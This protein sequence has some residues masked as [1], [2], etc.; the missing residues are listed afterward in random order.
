VTGPKSPASDLPDGLPFEAM[1]L[2]SPLPA[3]LTRLSDGWVLAVNDAWL[4]LTG[5]SREQAIGRSSVELGIWDDSN[6]RT[7]FFSKLPDTDAP[8][9]LR[10][11]GQL[12]RVRLHISVLQADTDPLLMGV[13]TGISRD[14]E[15]EQALEK[16]N[17]ELLRRLE[18]MEASERLAHLGHWTT[19]VDDET[20][21]WSKGLYEIAGLDQELPLNRQQGRSGIHP[22]DLPAWQ[23]ARRAL[24]G[25]E[26]TYRWR[27]PDGTI[28]WLRTR[29]A[30]TEV[31]GNLQTDFGVVQDITAEKA[32]SQALSEQLRFIQNVAARLPGIMF[33]GR[34][35]QDGRGSFLYVSDAVR[36]LL[37]LDPE[38]LRQ[39]GFQ[40]LN[41]IHEDDRQGFRSSLVA[42]TRNLSTWRMDFRAVLPKGPVRWFRAEALPERQADGSTV[43][44]GFAHDVT[45]SRAAVQAVERQHRMLEAVR[46]A[47][48]AFIEADDKRTAFEALLASFLGVTLSEYGFV[49]EVLFDVQDHPYLKT[50]AITNIAWD[51]ASR[52]WFD[53]QA[54]QGL[55]FRNLNTLFGAA[56]KTREPVISNDPGHDARS[57]GLPKGH[58]G[59]SAFLGIPIA[60]GGRLV[61]MVGLANQPGGYSLADVEFLQ[62]LLGAVSQLVLAYR[63]HAERDRARLQLQA[64]SAL[65]AE[66]SAALRLTFDTMGQGL[67]MVDAGGRVRFHNRRL[68]ELL[69]LPADL[70]DSQPLFGDVM[71]FQAARGDFGEGMKLVDPAVRPHILQQPGSITPERYLR[72][73]LEGRVLEIAS[74]L[75]PEGGLVRTYTDVTSYVEAE[76]ALR[77]ERQRLEWVLDA[78]R[79]GIWETNLVTLEMT[80]NDRWAEMLGYTAEELLPTTLNTWRRLVHPHDIGRA[81]AQLDAHWAGE[82]PY[83]ECDIRMRHKQ[84]HWVWINDRGQVH[85]RDENGRALYMSGTHLDISDRVAAQEEVRAL[86]ASLER[87]VAERTADLERSMRDVETISYSIAHDLRAPLRS[88][89]GFAS[90]IAEEDAE[91]LSPVARD[92]F[93]RIA[94]SSRNMGQMIT[95][96]LELL[97]VVRVELEAVPVDMAALA[98]SVAEVLAT[99]VPQALIGVQ[100]LPP[101]MGD[102]TLLRQV[103]LNLMD[104][105]LKYS[106]HQDQP[107]VVVGYDNAQRCYFVR[108]NGLGFDMARASKLFG[109]F[110]RLHAG[111]DVPGTGVGLAIVARIVERHG[112]RVWAEAQP[113]QG[114][115][116]RW[117]LPAL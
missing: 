33:Q 37:M 80:I 46:L 95:D 8:V 109:L 39:D 97:R 68:L 75:L 90:L 54:D 1:F 4:E 42:S 49:G 61:A 114:A 26:L 72:K 47:Q 32:A 44:Y 16:S 100:E 107:S 102:A 38:V 71:A 29:M 101:A 31:A 113:G 3:S 9:M 85:R 23:A 48:A 74:R 104:N 45:D 56:L 83:Y 30:R 18:L 64:T 60:A 12:C 13:M 93:N 41:R 87:R 11:R 94:K 91:R 110:Q 28:R 108:D 96:M 10:F 103:L 62:P 19:R 77:E 73:T 43:W 50:H 89:N 59:M 79:P 88:V 78:T 117:T 34:V 51:D 21:S 99:D 65:L 5:F 111:S 52:R 27:L 115:T 82:Y 2:A 98:N 6:D 66:K 81:Q 25:T 76:D 63:G 84:G 17:R 20:V 15:A 40:L 22:E 53:E 55:E 14:P 105:A 92:M 57:S 112:G 67:A 86:N 58:P 70:M 7:A 36:E 106:R 35:F 116:F 24:D 69:N